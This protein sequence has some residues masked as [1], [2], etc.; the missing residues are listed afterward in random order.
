MDLNF[1]RKGHAGDMNLGFISI[2]VRA[3]DMGLDE[4]TQGEGTNMRDYRID[5]GFGTLHHLEVGKMRK[6]QQKDQER[7]RI[8]EGR[9]NPPR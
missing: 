2:Q 4:M 3:S 1:K 6:N 8:Q 5:Q 9:R 7:V